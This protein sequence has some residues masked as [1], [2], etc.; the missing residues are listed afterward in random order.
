[1]HQ[2]QGAKE[3]VQETT[4]ATLNRVLGSIRHYFDDLERPEL[5]YD[6]IKRDMRTLFEDP[7]AGVEA[8]SYRL[9]Q[10]DRDTLTALLSTRT[11]ISEEQANRIIDQIEGARDSA[12]HQATR[13][14]EE[15]EKRIRAVKHEAQKQ[16]DEVRKSVATA[17]WW[18]FG[19]AITSVAT[20]AIA[21]IIAAG[22]MDLF[23]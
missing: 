8:L 17:A 5:N 16:A 9:S 6:A 20:A 4:Q 7:E 15:A 12:L 13:L 10:F 18:L 2:L 11:D 22:G 14:Q 3:Q 23:A 1:M 19:T 21:G